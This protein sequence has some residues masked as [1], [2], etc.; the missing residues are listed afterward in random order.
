MV[1]PANLEGPAV[2]AVCAA[3]TRRGP[4]R[5]RTRCRRGRRR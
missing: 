3:A 4:A 2:T 5:P 1:S